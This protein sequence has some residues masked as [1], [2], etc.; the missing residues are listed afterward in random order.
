MKTTAWR[1]EG[2]LVATTAKQR[3]DGVMQ[4]CYSLIDICQKPDIQPPQREDILRAVVVYAVSALDAYASDRFMEN[5]TRQIKGRRPSEKEVELLKSAGVTIEMALELLCTESSRP[6]VTIRNQVEKYFAT[7][8][9]QSF[10]RINELYEYFGIKCIAENAVRFAKRETLT[11][12]IE[13]MLN[14][15]H[16]IVHE[17]DYDGKH[18]LAHIKEKDVLKW[19]KAT[20]LFVESMESILQECLKSRKNKRKCYK[21]KKKEVA[22]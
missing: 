18:K 5:F 4:R 14:R 6:F 22:E 2:R 15:R 7:R 20:K 10:R 1:K 3:F 9:R 19:V 13:G 12:K 11:S 21:G 8:S 16:R 17:G